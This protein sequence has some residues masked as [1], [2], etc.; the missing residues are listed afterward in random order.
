MSGRMTL[1]NM[2]IEMGGKAGIVAP[3]KITWEYMKGRRKMKPFELD[4]DEDAKFAEAEISKIFRAG[5]VAKFKIEKIKPSLEDVFVS[6]IEE[7]D[8]KNG[9]DEPKKN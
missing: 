9:H 4:S 1:C 5:G 2:A 3:D 7:F 6:S 8:K